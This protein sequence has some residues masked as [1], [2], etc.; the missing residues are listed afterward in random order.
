MPFSSVITPW[1][2]ASVNVPSPS[3]SSTRDAPK[4][5]DTSRSGQPSEFTSAKLPVKDMSKV[6]VN[7][8]LA[9]IGT[10]ATSL[11]SVKWPLPLPQVSVPAARRQVAGPQRDE[12]IEVAVAVDV[13]ERRRERVLA[14]QRQA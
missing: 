3:L 6:G 2:V 12:E 5:A 9:K 10:P 14:R 1:S 4:S 11:T 7:S 13:A 8:A